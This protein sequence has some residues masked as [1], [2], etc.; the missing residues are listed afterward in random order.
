ME[1]RTCT[2]I[3]IPRFRK[4]NHSKI[5]HI[6]SNRKYIEEVALDMDENKILEKYL[7]KINQ[8][9]RD[10]EDRLSKNIELMEKRITEERR[11]SE[12]RMEKRFIESM[13]KIDK[14]EEKLDNK[15]DNTT[16]WVAATAIS[17]ILGIAAM[18][19]SVL[20]TLKK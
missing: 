19:I 9:R 3:E 12:E 1:E 14:L 2:V 18:V 6:K 10:Q 11:L 8:D 5:T 7:D 16:K 13:E 4:E 15:L 17:T 20:L